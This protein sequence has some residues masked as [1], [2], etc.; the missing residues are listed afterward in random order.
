MKSMRKIARLLPWLLLLCVFLYTVRLF[1][2]NARHNMDADIAS[3]MLLADICNQ[4][5]KLNLTDTWLYSTELR[6]VG[7]TPFM[8]LG[9]RLFPNNWTQAHAVAVVISMALYA[10]SVLFMASQCGFP[11]A[12]P[13]LASVLLMPLCQQYSY[14]VIYGLFYTMH[15]TI[16]FA[17]LGLVGMLTKRSDK[18]GK[19]GLI[20]PLVLLAL[21]GF[22]G[23]SNGVRMLVMV[24]GPMGLGALVLFC[25][26][27]GRY[28]KLS[29]AL[30][31]PLTRLFA[32]VMTLCV[33]A[34]AGYA[35]FMKALAPRFPGQSYA[36]FAVQDL[37]LS[38][39]ADQLDRL[40]H[41]FG[42]YSG[43]SFFSINGI[44][45]YV[46]VALLVLM[47][48]ALYWLLH[49]VTKLPAV[50]GFLALTAACALLMGIVFNTTLNM[51]LPRYYLFGI[52][53]L[54]LCG[55]IALENLPCKSGPLLAVLLVGYVG[56]FGYKSLE[57]TRKEI[58]ASPV[59]YEQITDWLLERGYTQG[60]A[61]IW[62][63]NV[64][65]VASNGQIETW[66]IEYIPKEPA[67]VPYL[68]GGLQKKSHMTE[69]PE[70]K[71]FLLVDDIENNFGWAPLNAEHL[72]GDWVC[73]G[74]YVYEYE[75]ADEM[76]A[77]LD[78]I[79]SM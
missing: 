40:V 24:Y 19:A 26:G 27:V 2:L 51:L 60:Y 5:G 75:S 47:A 69:R 52:I 77:Q 18:A 4:E 16:A 62:N 44:G 65:T 3:E 37:T 61:S 33:S 74:Y 34:L 17:V 23:G 42:F 48:L 55:F 7:S 68:W 50:H 71:I 64:L 14:I 43:D 21:L 28:E 36:A 30:C 54:I 63:A 45:C 41:F 13:W 46:T 59:G 32:A 49:R 15:M 29:E 1:A 6:I 31:Q 8:E 66:N 12:G 58:H 72:V 11:K 79:Q 39:I 53:L 38:G 67:M 20:I 10:A 70:G 57:Y 22:W 35:F 78:S 76:F 56:L 25:L 9:L 73:G